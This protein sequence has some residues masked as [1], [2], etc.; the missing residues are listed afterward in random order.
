[1]S[2]AAIAAPPMTKE[3]RG[4]PVPFVASRY[5]VMLLQT[6]VTIV[7]A[8]ELLFSKDTLLSREAQELVILGLILLVAGLTALPERIVGKGWFTGALALGDTAITSAVIYLS[9]NASSDLYLT[10]FVIILIAAATRTLKQ[11][12]MLSVVLYG[13]YGI[14]MYLDSS[15]AVLSEGHLIR[16]PLLLVMAIFYGATTETVRRISQEKS[17]LVDYISELKRAE[18]ELQKAKEAAEVA[19]RAKTEFLSTMSHEIRTPLNAIIGMADLLWDTPLNPEQQ[20]YV[21]IFRRT[22]N[23]LLSLINDL[24]DLS[25]VE[26]GHLELEST[27]FD[28]KE[29]VDNVA[30]MMSVRANEKGLQMLAQVMPDVPAHLIGDPNR[31][32]QILVNLIGNAIK[33]TEKGEVGLRIENDPQSKLPG[34]LKF[35]VTDTGIGIP[36]DKVNAVFEK[37]TQADSSVTRKYG[38]TGL[39]LAI[40]KQLVELMGGR[41]WVRS[42]LGRGS[43]FQFTTRLGV[44]TGVKPGASAPPISLVGIRPLIVDDN[45]TNRLIV[46][47]MLASWGAEAA[48]AVGGQ[49]ALAELA[50]AKTAGAPYNLVLLDYHMPG[51]DGF[52]VAEKISQ[53]PDLAGSTVVMLSSDVQSGD[54]IRA[55]KLGVAGYLVKPIR[56]TD[57]IRTITTALKQSQAA[58]QETPAASS[59][60]SSEPEKSLRLLLVDDSADNRMLIQSYL[61]KTPHH[62]DA[63]ENGLD[64]VE[65]YKAGE[66]D[67]VLLDMQ[68]PIM[69]GYTAAKVI[70]EWEKEHGKTA[71]PIIALT[72]YA[73]KEETQKSLDAGCTAHLTKPIKKAKLMETIA[74]QVRHPEKA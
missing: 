17:H 66:Y 37:F 56:Q 14:V 23:T 63:A 36:S 13:A 34:A 6:L 22:G 71:A 59:S 12:F 25:K 11:M 31:L 53:S 30:E 43:T 20:E 1:M 74:E 21:R 24:L 4:G 67:L 28:L 64:A 61:K 45:E 62:V 33:F 51:M 3:I 42:T 19:S 7:L 15:V 60:L 55:R 27:E 2:N 41:I 10:Y 38:G 35:S 57:L 72:A 65:K 54:L 26:A 8:Y 16:I 39:G 49:E 44:Q 73:L 52:Q 5:Q 48:E 29:V 32:R 47:Q 50:R 9:G 18:A 40:C 46:K 68:M 58:P 70:R 69:D